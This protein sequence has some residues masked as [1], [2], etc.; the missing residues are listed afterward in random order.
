MFCS[1]S[2]TVPE[3]PV[4]NRNNG[5]LFEKRLVEKAVKETGKDPITQEPLEIDDLVPV[6]TNKAVKPRP[7]PATSI[8]GLLGLFHNEWDALMLESHQQRTALITARQELAHAL[9]QQDAAVRVIARLTRE[10]DEARAA[11]ESAVAAARAAGPVPNGATAMEEDEPPSKRAKAGIT[12][13]IGEHMTEQ[14]KVLSKGRKKRVMPE[15][16]ASVDD[17]KNFGLL[18]SHPLHKSTKGGIL[19]IDAAPGGESLVATAGADGVVVLF[20]HSAGRIKASLTGHSKKVNGVKFVKDAST[21][22]SASA[23][24]TAR[25]WRAGDN[26]TY[27]AVHTL[28]DHTDS[29]TAVT[30]H[31]TG[32]YFVTASADRSWAFYDVA[33]GTCYTQVSDDAVKAG[34]TAAEFHP[35][36]MLLGTATSDSSIFVWETRLAKSVAS[37]SAH[38]GPVHSM[39]FSENG[40]Y[41]ATAA[42][43]GVKLW[44]LRKLKNFQSLDA[45]SMGGSPTAARFDLSGLYLAVGGTNARVVGSKQEWQDLADLSGAIGK[46]SVSALR[47]T[48]D[49]KHL[50]VGSNDHNL[51]VFGLGAAE[52]TTA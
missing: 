26:N 35:D 20:D 43:D 40:Y 49:A 34:Y 12:K 32:D 29:V 4:V 10:R 15:G 19:S 27:S 44:D 46:K 25:I 14:S 13:E 1:I 18:S 31:A 22:L 39:C 2:G 23:D 45:P 21:L 3:E 28:K 8:P 42:D 24:S 6:K 9:Y 36:G 11:M 52:E 37:L 51:R 38:T 5:Q 50:Y 17:V 7:S 16:L 47:W 30:V 48:S 33:T 41:L